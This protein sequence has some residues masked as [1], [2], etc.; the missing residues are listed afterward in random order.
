M[1]G[2]LARGRFELLG[3]VVHLRL[4]VEHLAEPRFEHHQHSF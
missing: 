3:F 1:R 4:L 2:G